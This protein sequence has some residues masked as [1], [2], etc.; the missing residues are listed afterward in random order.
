M[1][2]KVLPSNTTI[3]NVSWG[4]APAGLAKINAKGI[5]K[6]IA[7]G[8]VTVT[9]TAWDGSG[10]TA[11]MDITITNQPG[12]IAKNIGL[13]NIDVF[14]NP[15]SNGIFTIRGIENISHIVILDL[16]GRQVK[17]LNGLKQNSVEIQL[18]SVPGIYVI[19]LYSGQNPAYKRIIVK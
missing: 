11:T 2:A 5:L 8:K 3:P 16:Y 18:K 14:P 9:A 12:S 13:E 15:V 4:A 10:I 7:N 6:A 17:E 1:L 19:K